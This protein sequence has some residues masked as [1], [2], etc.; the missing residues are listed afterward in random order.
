M[1]QS[2]LSVLKSPEIR[3]IFE[4][5]HVEHAY[6]VGSCARG[7]EREDSDIDVVFRKRPGATLTLFNVGN[8]KRRL[9]E[10]LGRSVDLVSEPSIRPQFVEVFEKD[11]FTLF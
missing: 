9:E 2:L 3:E 11:K 8:M 1:S 4:R 5:N 10:H 6:V 7:E